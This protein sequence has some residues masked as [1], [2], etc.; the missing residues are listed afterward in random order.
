M[1][2]NTNRFDII[3]NGFFYFFGFTENPTHN[4]VKKILEDSPSEK[5]RTDLKKINNDYRSQYNQMRKEILCLE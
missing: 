2:L 1:E 4:E 5:I 3:L